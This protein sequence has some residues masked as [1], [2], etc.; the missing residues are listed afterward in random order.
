MGCYN[1]PGFLRDITFNYVFERSI[2]HDFNLLEAS[3]NMI[4]FMRNKTLVSKSKSENGEWF[5]KSCKY[6][7]SHV[8]IRKI[9]SIWIFFLT[10]D[11][12]SPI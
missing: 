11:R 10:A 2:L 12:L 5:D 6:N 8:S 3:P 7:F 4:P 9:A 1:N